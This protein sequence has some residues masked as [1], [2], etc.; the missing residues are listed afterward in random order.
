MAAALES[1]ALVE[2]RDDPFSG[3]AARVLRVAAVYRDVPSTKA[4]TVAVDRE[5]ADLARWLKL[6]LGAPA[7][8]AGP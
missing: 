2:L 8:A 1:R 5:I 6:D 7:P 3:R 4:M